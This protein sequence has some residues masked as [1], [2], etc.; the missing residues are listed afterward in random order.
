MSAASG[1]GVSRRSFLAGTAGVIAGATGL[2]GGAAGLVATAGTAAAQPSRI[3]L[4]RSE[5]RVVVIGS[6]FGGGVAALRLTRAGVPVLLLERGREWRTGPNARTFPNAANPDERILWHRSAPELF[7]RKL[8]VD[9]YVGLIDAVVGD[10]ITALAPAG[11]G[12]GSLIY[13]GMSLKPA[14]SVFEEHLPI[15]LDW[16]RMNRVHYPRVARM[17]QL[18]VAPDRLV[19][20]P[21]YSAARAFAAHARRAGKP[22]SKI[23]MPIDWNYALA[24]LR[25]EMTPSYTDGSGALGVNNGGKHSVDVTYV[26]QARATGRLTV[27][28]LHEVTD[29]SRAPDGRW[30]VHVDRTDLRGRLLERK[31]IT[32]KTLIMSAGSVHT[33]R[34]LV[35]AKATGSIGDLPDAVGHGWGTNADRIYTWSV[36]GEDFGAK[37][38]GPVVYGSLNWADPRT[39]HTVIQA[40]IPPLGTDLHS[41]MMVG[42][43]VSRDRG[44]FVYDTARNDASLRWPSGGDRAIQWQHIHPTATAI[45]GPGSALS[46]SNSMVNTTWHALGGACMGTVCDLSGRVHG[47]RGLYVV[48]GALLPGNAAACNPSMTIAAVAERALDDLVVNDVGRLI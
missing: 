21:Q 3:R 7:G 13:Q 43:G 44:R 48:D 2:A 28:T 40:S 35:R 33:T 10:N 12:G 8:D 24:E 31:I 4:T 34:L 5:Q 27:A 9:P 38:G 11:L 14:Q 36:P 32:T 26:K 29:V 6:G 45:A 47:Q 39:A 16:T 42:Y 25:G 17:L 15:G 30:R 1:T 37:Q 18:A 41:T 19:R 46:D 23:P 22:V 20:T